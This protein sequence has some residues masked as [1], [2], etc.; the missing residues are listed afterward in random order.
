MAVSH[1]LTRAPA[2]LA[3]GAGSEF[4][5][6]P[7][8]GAGLS[9]TPTLQKA[10]GAARRPGCG[11]TFPGTLRVSVRGGNTCARIGLRP[12]DPYFHHPQSS[13]PEFKNPWEVPESGMNLGQR[14]EN[15]G[16]EAALQH[17]LLRLQGEEHGGESKTRLCFPLNQAHSDPP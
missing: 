1:V 9:G 13:V 15:P 8:P 11:D 14:S 16:S 17:G 12:D 2:L 7:T 4:P 10:E 3:C 5:R 6:S